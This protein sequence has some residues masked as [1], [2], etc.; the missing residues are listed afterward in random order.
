MVSKDELVQR[1]GEVEFLLRSPLKSDD[2]IGSTS[3]V[4]GLLHTSQ[5]PKHAHSNPQDIPPLNY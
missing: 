4:L 3:V 5:P 2:D 1:Y